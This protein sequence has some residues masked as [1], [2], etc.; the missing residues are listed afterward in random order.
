MNILLINCNQFLKKELEEF[1]GRECSNIFS[2]ASALKA[3]NI[4][5]HNSID[6]VLLRM[7]T[8]S[9]VALLNYINR[10]YKKIKVLLSAERDLE[11]VIF[12]IK[13]GNYTILH[14]QDNL[15]EINKYFQSIN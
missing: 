12:S 15:A 14:D 6:M 5:D 4:L 11:D 13:D 2:T 9:D 3:I 8:I 1:I 7:N 10:N